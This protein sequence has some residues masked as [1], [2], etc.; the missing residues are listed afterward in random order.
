[1]I[2]TIVIGTHEYQWALWPFAALF[3][4]YWGSQKVIYF[5]DRQEGDL[6]PNIEFRRVPCYSEGVWPW[7]HWFGN[8]FNSIMAY[9]EGWIVCVFLPDHWLC[10]PVYHRGIDLLGYY[11][12][13]HGDVVR[14]NVT[15]KTAFYNY[16]HHYTNWNGLDVWEVEKRHPDAGLDGGLTFSTSLWNPRLARQIIEPHWNLWDCELLGTRKFYNEFPQWRVVGSFPP[17]IH[18]AQGLSH[19]VLRGVNLTEL[20]RK[21]DRDLVRPMIPAGWEIIE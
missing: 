18:R 10:E 2:Q 17:P 9:L 15:A 7:A 3:A 6:P 19:H 21:E 16:G 5:A 8:G 14:G 20:T 12:H 11:M 4:K 13:L 1:M